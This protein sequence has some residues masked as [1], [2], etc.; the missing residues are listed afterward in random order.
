MAL[1]FPLL[2]IGFLIVQ[3]VHAL[4]QVT[5]V[6]ITCYWR[7]ENQLHA[8][9]NGARLQNGHCAVDP[10]KIPY[11]SRV[12]LDDEE[13]VAVDTGP[14]VVNRKAARRSGRNTEERDA[15]VIDRYFET[16]SQAVEWQ[17]THPDFMKVRVITPGA[18]TVSSEK[19]NPAPPP[20]IIA[21]P[22]RTS[23]A[24]ALRPAVLIADL[25]FRV[26]PE[27]INTVARNARTRGGSE[28]CF[29]DLARV[30]RSSF[31]PLTRTLITNRLDHV[32]PE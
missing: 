1:R 10:K 2:T 19:V 4:D 5:L 27:S 8:A 20:K 31:D 24:E 32:P 22:P 28:L 26:L 13:L 30:G 16:K 25:N 15:M 21:P 7:A 9:S 29:D 11:R 18:A 3:A 23:P 6:R 17:K 12:V 14:A